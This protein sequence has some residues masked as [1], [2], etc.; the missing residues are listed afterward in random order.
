MKVAAASVVYAVA[1]GLLFLAALVTS[2]L[3]ARRPNAASSTIAG[4]LLRPPRQKAFATVNEQ[5]K[6]DHPQHRE[7]HKCSTRGA[8]GLAPV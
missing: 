2:K 5:L 6:V 7:F 8:G 3:S 1:A 4:V